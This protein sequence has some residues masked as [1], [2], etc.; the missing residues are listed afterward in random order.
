MSGSL[1]TSALAELI[2]ECEDEESFIAALNDFVASCGAKHA[3]LYRF[4]SGLKAAVDEWAP[5][6]SSFP[7]EITKFYGAEGCA[8]YDPFL[9]AALRATTPVRFLEVEETFETSQEITALFDLM[10][11]HGLRDG[12]SM[13]IS[14]RF[15][16]SVYFGLAYDSELDHMSEFDRRRIQACFQMFM[17]HAGEILESK[18]TRE[19]S[20]KEREVIACLAR[21]ES[22]KQIARSLGVAPSTVNTLMNRSFEKLGVKNRT[23]AVIAACRIGL[24]LVA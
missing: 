13:H 17:R 7:E 12:L 18:E 10:R 8:S 23:E 9:R 19:L 2:A 21:G 16:H 11:A 3:V 15:G 14:D 20:P 24:S 22:N 1:S 4:N 5:I 6:Y